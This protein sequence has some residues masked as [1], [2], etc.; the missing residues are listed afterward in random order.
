MGFDTLLPLPDQNC[1]ALICYLN[2]WYILHKFDDLLGFVEYIHKT[3]LEERA[4]QRASLAQKSLIFERV[5]GVSKLAFCYAKSRTPR[6][7]QTNPYSFQK[8]TNH[9][10]WIFYGAGE[11]SRT[12]YVHFGKVTFCR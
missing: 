12:P 10:G 7:G 2:P 11:G 9:K 4:A 8:N 6:S 1:V 5:R 3:S